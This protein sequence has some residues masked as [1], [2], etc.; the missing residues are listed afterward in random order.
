[1]PQALD[2][3]KTWQ[4]FTLHNMSSR[5]SDIDEIDFWHNYAEGYDTQ[6]EQHPESYQETLNLIQSHLRCDDTVL[7]VG[8][9]S[10]RFTLP[11]ASYVQS[12]TALDLSPHMLELL[13]N[14]AKA[15]DIKNIYTVQCNWEDAVIQQHDV[16]LAA[17]SLYR[18]RDMLRSLQKLINSTRRTLIIVDGDYAPRPDNDPPHEFIKNEIWGVDD[19]GICNYLYFAGMLRQC[20][21]RAD[22]H[23]VRE[24]IHYSA[25]D[26]D[27]LAHH[28]VPHNANEQDTRTFIQKFEP[29]IKQASD[30][31]HYTCQF[32]VGLVIWNRPQ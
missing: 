14:K 16:V 21:V 7:D 9:G 5:L 23:V 27:T 2:F 6:N 24:K 32:A 10:G 3:A 28:F 20:R 31:Y 1:M 22:I 13:Q 25:P 29:Y 15:N 11:I 4:D 30:S 19:P 12:V 17:W 26:V 18:Q 8:A